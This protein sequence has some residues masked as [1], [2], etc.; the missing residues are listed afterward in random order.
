LEVQIV[1]SFMKPLWFKL[2]TFFNRREYKY[3]EKVFKFSW[4]EYKSKKQCGFCL[5][6]RVFFFWHLI[7]DISGLR[8]WIALLHHSVLKT[9]LVVDCKWLKIHYPIFKTSLLNLAPKLKFAENW[10][11]KNGFFW[12]T[13]KFQVI[14]LDMYYFSERLWFPFQCFKQLSFP[15]QIGNSRIRIFYSNLYNLRGYPQ[16]MSRFIRPFK[17]LS[18]ITEI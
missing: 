6:S 11:S 18:L 5:I 12:I 7:E 13:L 9:L 8:G 3:S 14:C 10:E 2:I 17:K 1:L 16:M 15:P 4:F